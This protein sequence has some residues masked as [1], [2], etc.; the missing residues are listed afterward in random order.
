M[1]IKFFLIYVALGAAFL[2]VSL[3]VLLTGGKNAKAVN[4][5]YRLGGLMLS[6]WAMLS[7]A[8]CNPFQVTCYDPVEPDP[9]VTCYDVYV[10]EDNTNNVEISLKDKQWDAF[11]TVEAGDIFMVGIHKPTYS[12]Y[13]F[14][15]GLNN[16]EGTPL[17]LTPLTIPESSES[18]EEVFLFEVPLSADLDYKGEAIA[19]LKGVESEDPLKLTQMSY[20]IVVINLK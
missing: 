16:T 12:Q 4:A 19:E 11:H 15:I 2:G 9:A 14:K 1:K 5:K 13:V 18:S 3:W 20:S 17:Q 7:A 8:S 6:A 10:E